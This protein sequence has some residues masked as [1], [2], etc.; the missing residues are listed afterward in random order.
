MLEYKES[1]SQ[2]KKESVTWEDYFAANDKK[3]MEAILQKLYNGQLTQE[4]VKMFLTY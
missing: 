1:R 3:E 2:Q 4:E